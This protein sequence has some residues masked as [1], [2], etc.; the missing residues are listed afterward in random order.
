MTGPMARLERAV[1]AALSA[2]C[3]LSSVIVVILLVVLVFIR[4]FLGG[5]FVSGH[6]LSLMAAVFLYMA[7]AVLAEKRGTQITVDF[8][9]QTLT[10]P[11]ARAWH[12]VLVAALTVVVCG[13]FL[14]WTYSMFAWG[15]KRPQMNPVL[16]I[17]IW[18]PQLSILIG[19]VGC[20]GYSLRNLLGGFA[21]LKAA[22]R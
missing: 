13:F 9:A 17:P 16:D 22:S 15:L 11:R 20:L 10:S 14:Y 21:D 12:R 19:A 5:D 3:F 18:I 6:E 8:L 7:G 2:V 4:F 1:E